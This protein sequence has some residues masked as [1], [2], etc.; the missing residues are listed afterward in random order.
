M[1]YVKPRQLADAI[2]VTTDAL[3]KQRERGTSPYEYEV[4]EGRVLYHF[5]T[6]PPSVRNNIEKNTTKRTRE[7]HYD[8]KD[9]RYW[10][11]IGKRNEQ[12]IQQKNRR[13]EAKVQE[14]L[15]EEHA[16]QTP[17]RGPRPKKVYAYWSDPRTTGNYWNSIEDYEKSKA[18]KKPE[19]FY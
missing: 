15:A 3:R 6:L 14:R 9:P 12:R 10:N 19:P 2:S 1:Q 8:I 4:I 11:S 16:K 17:S 7:K 18:E 13:I 5:I